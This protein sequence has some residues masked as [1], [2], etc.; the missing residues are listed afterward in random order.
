M[1]KRWIRRA[2]AVAML[3]A[4]Y[5]LSREGAILAGQEKTGNRGTIVID[6]GHGGIDPG[7]VGIDGLEE[8]GINLKIAGYLGEYLREE[9]YK[10]VFT[11]EDDGDFMMKTAAIRKNRIWKTVV[12]LLK[13]S[14]LFLR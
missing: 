13:K 4:I 6:S 3:C 14:P 8:K 10:I 12:P 5:L 1:W 9:G 2:M 7:V 11:R